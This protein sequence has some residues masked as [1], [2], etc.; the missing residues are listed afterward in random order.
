MKSSST[1]DSNNS[2]LPLMIAVPACIVV[3]IVA[4]AI[5]FLQRSRTCCGNSKNARSNTQ[6]VPVS[7]R[8]T[9]SY[10]SLNNMPRT[11]LH[12][13]PMHCNAPRSDIY[14]GLQN[15]HLM[16]TSKEKLSLSKQHSIDFYT[17][18]SSVSQQR[19]NP[20]MQQYGY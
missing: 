12:I 2:S 18:I 15:P 17:D 3:I 20:Q 7:T 8:D 19:T 13:N 6:F 9:E 5:C 1:S 11:N 4:F 14:V 16:Q 10:P